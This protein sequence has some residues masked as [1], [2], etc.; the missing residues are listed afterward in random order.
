MNQTTIALSS[1]EVEYVGVALVAKERIWIKAILEELNLFK[2]PTLELNCDNQS[3]IRLVSNPRIN[4]N[5]RHISMKHHFLREMIEE[6]KINIKFTPTT[7]MWADFLTKAV[8]SHNHL[9]CY[10]NIELLNHTK[11]EDKNM[12]F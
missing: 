8:A 4:D 12:K 10:K 7:L 3:C 5:I 11:T 1:T 9:Q 6:K 2:V